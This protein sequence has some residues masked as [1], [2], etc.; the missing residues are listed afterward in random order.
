MGLKELEE[1]GNKSESSQCYPTTWAS[2]GDT[3]HAG[4][5]PGS[6]RSPERGT[7]THSSILARRIPWIEEPGGLHTATGVQ[8]VRQDLATKTRTIP[9]F[10]GSWKTVYLSA[11]Y[12]RKTTW[13]SGMVSLTVCNQPEHT[14][15]AGA[16]PSSVEAD[17]STW[18]LFYNCLTVSYQKTN[19][20]YSHF[21]QNNSFI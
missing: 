19:M 21:L 11:S 5:T 15:N 10:Q 6:G 14:P 4:F 2:A 3:R 7:A 13:V 16:H 8:R 20:H 18:L 17:E 9:T 12:T 1:K